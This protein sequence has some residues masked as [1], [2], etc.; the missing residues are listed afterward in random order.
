[1]GTTAQ[2]RFRQSDHT[3][4]NIFG[5]LEHVIKKPEQAFAAKKR[6]AEYLVLDAV[7]GNTDRHHENWGILLKHTPNGRKGM[8]APSFDH[9]SSLGR[10]LLD[11]TAGKCRRRILDAGRIGEYVEKASGG[12]YWATSDKRA[13]SPLE[14]VRRAAAR[15]PEYF[16]HAFARLDNLN[17]PVL[18]NIVGRVPN[19]WMSDVARQFAIELT[20]YNLTELRRIAV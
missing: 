6:I 13:V 20:C 14:L 5:A 12:I 2:R 16:R 10:E 17:S 18:E 9:A 7:V 19:D 15:Y 8:V 3:L 11:S 1:V 4:G